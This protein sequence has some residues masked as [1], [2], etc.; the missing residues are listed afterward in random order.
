MATAELTVD[1]PDSK[2]PSNLGGGRRIELPFLILVVTDS[3]IVEVYCC[4][5]LHCVCVVLF[6]IWQ[7]RQPLEAYHYRRERTSF[8]ATSKGEFAH[9]RS[10]PCVFANHIVC[11]FLGL[12]WVSARIGGGV[13]SNWRLGRVLTRF[14]RGRGYPYTLE[15]IKVS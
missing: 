9:A 14:P 13:V 11:S 8:W 1:G 2:E 4:I 15:F 3:E 12:F 10:T 5:L 7:P 6:G